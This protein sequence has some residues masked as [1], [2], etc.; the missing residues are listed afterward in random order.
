MSGLVPFFRDFLADYDD[1][2][3]IE[4][5]DDVYEQSLE[6][7]RPVVGYDTNPYS[8]GLLTTL[9]KLEYTDPWTLQDV[10]EFQKQSIENYFYRRIGSSEDL[11]DSEDE[12]SSSS[13]EEE[14]EEDNEEEE[15]QPLETQQPM[16]PEE[17]SK[18][19]A[20]RRDPPARRHTRRIPH[21][22]QAIHSVTNNLEYMD[23]LTSELELNDC[24]LTKV[25]RFRET[26]R[27]IQNE[28][29]YEIPIIPGRL[30]RLAIPHRDDDGPVSSIYHHVISLELKTVSQTKTK[31]LYVFLYNA[32]AQAF[33]QWFHGEQRQGKSQIVVQMQQVPGI[34]IFPFA[35]DRRNWL[36]AEE[37]VEYCLCI[38]DESSAKHYNE[39]QGD[40]ERLRLDQPKMELRFFQLAQDKARQRNRAATEELVLSTDTIDGLKPLRKK[41]SF[42]VQIPSPPPS[43]QQEEEV[44]AEPILEDDDDDEDDE[45]DKENSAQK[46]PLPVE[47]PKRKQP[48][49]EMEFVGDAKRLKKGDE[50]IHYIK[51]NELQ[52]ALN[53]Q[54]ENFAIEF[55]LYA[56]VLVFTCARQTRRGDWM[57]SATLV[58]D[59]V[60]ESPVTA[61]FFCSEKR[62][63]PALVRAGDVL[64][65]HNVHIDTYKGD[66]QIQGREFSSYV[67]I[68]QNEANDWS[69]VPSETQS[70]VFSTEDSVR[71][72]RLW[73]WAKCFL[74]QYPLIK[75]QHRFTIANLAVEGAIDGRVFDRDLTVMVS[76]IFPNPEETRSSHTP[77]G[78]LRV[79]D[80][81]GDGPNDP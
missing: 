44:E 43:P 80:G 21:I 7:L 50:T 81:T 9:I 14:E 35:I 65:M 54:E 17:A 2:E 28:S 32:Y 33:D 57:V 45:E 61:I 11:S 74:E 26:K 25:W 1:Y 51:L 75:P 77:C 22:S 3:H 78:F 10:R 64:R 4:E 12:Y 39:E 34:C 18:Q 49:G 6:S 27:G 24:E 56:T 40:Y 60:N 71:S 36:D 55:N 38:G 29:R 47:M 66:I 63:L 58:D 48:L 31:R 30:P 5:S 72:Q 67:V 76:A 46:R 41:A 68:R 37:L 52:N 59:T 16:I 79:W 69:V 20:S 42:N 8:A 70:F 23:M 73:L 15:E 19:Q 53:L 13:S 62:Y